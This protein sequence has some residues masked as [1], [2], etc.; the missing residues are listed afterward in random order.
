MRQE[1]RQ[2]GGPFGFDHAVPVSRVRVVF[3]SV[4][5]AY[6][7]VSE[8]RRRSDSFLWDLTVRRQPTGADVMIPDWVWKR[9]P[10]IKR[11]AAAYGGDV[12]REPD[13]AP[14]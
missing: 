11:V 6:N 7:F 4:A 2:P 9:E 8:I 12:R 13:T 1:G 3:R 10:F 5:V 14:Y